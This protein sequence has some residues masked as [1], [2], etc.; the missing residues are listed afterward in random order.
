MKNVIHFLVGRPKP[1]SVNGVVK[2]VYYLSKYEATYSNSKVEVWCI[3]SKKAPGEYVLDTGIKCR[4]FPKNIMFFKKEIT[5]EIKKLKGE[6]IFHLHGVFSVYNWVLAIILWQSK[7]KYLVSPHGALRIP[8]LSKNQLKKKIVKP[9]VKF[10]IKKASKLRAISKAEAIDIYKFGVELEKIALIPNG[11]ELTPFASLPENMLKE[12]FQRK[13]LTFI[14]RLD[15][16]YKGLD[17]LLKALAEVPVFTL[18]LIGPFFTKNDKKRIENLI[19]KENIKEIVFFMGRM[20]GEKKIEFL[21]G[22]FFFVHPSRSEGLPLSVL[23]ALSQGIPVIVS[24]SIDPD[25]IIEKNKAG[26][27][28]E[29]NIG[30]LIE[31]LLKIQELSFDEWLEM[32]HS[33]RRLIENIFQWDK[34]GEE[35]HKIYST[36]N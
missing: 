15:V 13:I 28:I 6:T 20:Y 32:K 19:D 24:T 17:I 14:G 34:I 29:A 4:I 11:V 23:E 9:F 7:I 30:S 31:A 35:M 12:I 36:I 22:T 18:Y 2:A 1:E 21:R 10:Y 5:S 25:R 8:A 16:Y 27:T 3:S 26:L 33:A